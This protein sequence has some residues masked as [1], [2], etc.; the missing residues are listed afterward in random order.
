[1][2]FRFSVFV[3][4]KPGPELVKNVCLFKVT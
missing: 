1:M 3:S 4:S 2:L